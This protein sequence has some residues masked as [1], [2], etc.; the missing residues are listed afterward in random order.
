MG[1]VV[2]RPIVPGN[3]I[4]GLRVSWNRVRGQ[5]ITYE[6]QNKTVAS[7]EWSTAVSSNTT[8][9]TQNL[10]GLDPGTRYDV[11]VRAVSSDGNGAWTQAAQERTYQC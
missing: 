10:T 4:V 5:D 11:R 3:N 8:T 7:N 9:L 6:V 2:V 1:T